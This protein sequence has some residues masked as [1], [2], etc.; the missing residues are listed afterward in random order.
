MTCAEAMDRL[1]DYVDGELS[2]AEF[3]EVELHLGTCAACR[4]EERRL[5]AV[6]AHAAAL[7]R[8]ATPAR[9]LW[10]EIADA[11]THRPRLVW[12][13]RRPALVPLGIAA[14]LLIAAVSAAVLVRRQPG[15]ALSTASAPVTVQPA[16]L[17]GD[18]PHLLEAEREYDRATSELL[19]AL[20]ARRDS[21]SPATVA[22]VE[23]NL[24]TIDQALA[25]IRAALRQDPTSPELNHLLTSTHQKKLEVLQQVIRLGARL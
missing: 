14:A 17:T 19:A 15:P 20:N 24:R 21:L 12:L 13:P 5:R 1:D 6:L 8:E 18:P 7:P 22:M 10:P 23:E 3:Q 16:A 11:I 25:Q 4:D 9:D 2:E